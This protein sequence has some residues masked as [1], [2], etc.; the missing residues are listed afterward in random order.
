MDPPGFSGDF[1]VMRYGECGAKLEA[2]SH[3]LFTV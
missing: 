2:N 1:F 3:Q